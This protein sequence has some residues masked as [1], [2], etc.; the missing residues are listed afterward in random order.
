MDVHKKEGSPLRCLIPWPWG[1]R[2]LPA[3]PFA[4]SVFRFEFHKNF[5]D[6]TVYKCYNAFV[7][8]FVFFF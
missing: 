6:G 3:V 5:S 2:P 4:A 1:K 8:G 7:D